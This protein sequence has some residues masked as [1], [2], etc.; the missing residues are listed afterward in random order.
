MPYLAKIYIYPI[1]S[2]DGVELDQATLLP[3]GALA[4]DR[5]FALFDEQGAVVNAKR[6]A[7]IQTI[8]SAFDLAA[9]TITLWVQGTDDRQTFHLDG[10][11]SAIE[12]WLSNY[13]GFPIHLQQNLHMGFP[14]DT[15]AS[16][17]TVASIASL[18]AV[19]TWFDLSLE[20]VRRR[21]R[22]NLEV[23]ETPAFWEDQL[24]A[25]S[26]KRVPFQIGEVTLLGNNPCQR[27]IVP[28]RNPWTGEPLPQFQKQFSAKRLETLPSW[29]DRA[30]FKHFYKLTLNTCVSPSETGKTLHVG[31]SIHLSS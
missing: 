3:G 4:G 18:E 29:S 15:E 1:K 11:R 26:D 5:E 24:Y 27:C 13:L 8:R 28:T 17:P 25:V 12:T 2:L 31:D 6:T 20:E 19:T 14:D 30:W 10:D 21:F 9:R 23:A 16:G 7:H 22:T